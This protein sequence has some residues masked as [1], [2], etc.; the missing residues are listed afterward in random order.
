MDKYETWAQETVKKIREK[1]DWVSEKNKDRIPYTA[2]ASGSYDD[3]SAAG[4]WNTDD[5]INWWTNGFWG[6]IH[7]LLYQDTGLEKYKAVARSCEKKLEACF[8]RFYGLHHDIGFMYLP[9]AA[10]SYRITGCQSSRKTA[11][12]AA[13]LLAGRFNPAGNYIRA[14]NDTPDENR[15]GFTI[16]DSMLNISLLYWASYETGDPRFC[17]T[18]IRHAD[19]IQKFFIRPDG[20]AC[21]IGIFDPD[22]GA[23]IKSLAGQGYAE[24]SSWSRGQSWAVYGFTNSYRHTKNPSYLQTAKRCAHYCISH[25]P[26]NGLIPCDYCQP[27]ESAWEDSCAACILA[28]GLIELARF[29]PEEEKEQLMQTA[30]RILT[31]ID[32]MRADWSKN[33]DA[34]VQNCT[35][36]WHD[37]VHHITMVYADY[38]FMEA[39]YKL[40]HTGILIW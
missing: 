21:H 4:A 30:L 16:I 18:A 36:A 38:F 35:G 34:I 37:K 5:G 28:C 6:G 15:S 29:V 1:M 25:I 24:G 10:A 19:T 14:W 32:D 11:L 9:T 39:V 2:D 23:F 12:H 20:S 7:W 22:T 3:R 31:A 13:N 40:L 8:S 27:E 26:E 17:Q 33:C